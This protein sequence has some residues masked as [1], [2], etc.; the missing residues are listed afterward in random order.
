MATLLQSI[1]EMIDNI[2]VTDKQ[3][4]SIETSTNNLDGHITNDE[5][6][7]DVKSTFITGSYYR[8]T[9]LRPL[10]DVDIFAV[11]DRKEWSDKYGNLPKPQAV[12]TK[13][14]NKLNSISDYKDKVSQDR[15]CVTVKLSDKNFDILPSFEE[16]FGGYLIPN[17]DL[18]SWTYSYPEELTKNLKES[19]KNND[20][21]LKD[22]IKAVKYWNRENKKYI[23]S[24]HI[25]ETMITIF[26]VNSFTNYE[27][28]I[29]LWF[30]N[31]QYYLNKSRFKTE[32]QYNKSIENVIA[33]KDELNKAKAHLDKKENA[34]AIQI[35]K[36]LFG[37]EFP[38][39]DENEAKNFAKKISTGSLKVAS[40]GFIS[41]TVGR[42]IPASKGF[43][44]DL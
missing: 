42:N 23:P 30:D 11:L 38:V 14:K 22:I 20:Y 24:F 36:D 5:N 12:L 27:E 26:S 6:D 21:K 39:A 16:S 34:E 35:W 19:H 32:N 25:E 43:Y 41:D 37:K 33:V 8:D 15:P 4:E 13:I 44:G 9:I 10:D 2:S 7:L 40:T 1:K 28:G 3:E 31:A 29:R 18:E 17:H